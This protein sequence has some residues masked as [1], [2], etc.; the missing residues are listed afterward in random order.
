MSVAPICSCAVLLLDSAVF[1]LCVWQTWSQ[2]KIHPVLWPRPS[3]PANA[4]CR[5]SAVCFKVMIISM[6]LALNVAWCS[7]AGWCLTAR[8]RDYATVQ[9]RAKRGI[10][11][12]IGGCTFRD[13]VVYKVIEIHT[14]VHIKRIATDI[15][16]EN[17][18]IGQNITWVKF[19]R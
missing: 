13:A 11:P 7:V 19:M 3:C 16:L 18:S 6:V 14:I 2:C 8:T 4:L 17:C 10:A 1:H 5:Q 12:V 15:L 9:W